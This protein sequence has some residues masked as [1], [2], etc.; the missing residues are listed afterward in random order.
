[1][2]IAKHIKDLMNSKGSS[3]I[4]KMFE[5]GIQLKAK[6]GEDKVYDFSL[7]NPD[8]P[9]PEKIYQVV[10]DKLDDSMKDK[11]TNVTYSV[12]SENNLTRLD[13]FVECEIDLVG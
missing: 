1:M 13:C 4:R 6:F 7:G 2:A 8:M 9:P 11:I 5:E 3:V 12:V 10:L